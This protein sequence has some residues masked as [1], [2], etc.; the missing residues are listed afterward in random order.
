MKMITASMRLRKII[1]TVA[2]VLGVVGVGVWLFSLIFSPSVTGVVARDNAE[3]VKYLENLG[4]KV[5]SEPNSADKVTVPETFDEIYE[6][7]NSIQKECGFDL[8]DKK[9][10]PLKRYTYKV[11]N[12]PEQKQGDTVLAELLINENDEI[13]GGSIYSLRLD[14][15]MTG[16][17][18]K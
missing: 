4:W 9:G 8:S 13:V 3:R 1:A 2:I 10:Q 14:G 5:E 17:C 12:H 6:Y 16:L 18:K 11:L 15:F 7:Y